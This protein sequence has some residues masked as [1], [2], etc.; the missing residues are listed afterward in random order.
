MS[1]PA[2]AALR[3]VVGERNLLLDP[4]DFAAVRADGRGDCGGDPLAILRPSSAEEV[5]AIALLL[6]LEQEF[7]TLLTVFEGMS[8][9]AMSAALEHMPTLP[10]PFRQG[11]PGYAVLVELSAGRA[12]AA[13]DLEERLGAALMPFMDGASPAVQDVVVDHRT[14]LWAIRHA[15]PEGLRARGSVLAC[16][17]ALLRGDVMRFR[18]DLR[19]RLAK[20]EPAL[21]LHD[22]GHI[23]DGGLHF[24]LVWPR[25]RDALP[26]ELADR[27]RMMIVDAVVREYGGSFSAE[28]GVGPRN[29]AQ[30]QRFTSPS[31]RRLAGAAQRLFAP[32]PLGRVDFGILGSE[33]LNDVE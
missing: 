19:D 3:A 8:E 2:L 24:N 31:E 6:A 9:R 33:E 26:A 27:A 23:G 30:Y 10:C 11:V 12:F 20:L 25:G 18:D 32:V 22:F 15:V 17:I 29:I 7:G 16:D 21:E 14:G 4:A 1:A 13:E 28:H 5:S